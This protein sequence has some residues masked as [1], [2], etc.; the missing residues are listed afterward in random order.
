MSNFKIKQSYIEN[1]VITLDTSEGES[2]WSESRIRSSKL[3]Q[4]DV[5]RLARKIFIKHKFSNILDIGSGPG[6]KIDMFFNDIENV[7][8]IDQPSAKK[9]A[10]KICPHATFHEFNLDGKKN[11]LERKFDLLINADVIEHLHNPDAM[12]E[13]IEG[14]MH[15]KS[16]V[17]ISTPDRDIRRGKFN[18]QSPNPAHVREWNKKELKSYLES[19]GLD[20]IEQINLPISKIN[21]VKHNFAK[22]LGFAFRM[23]EWQGCQMVIAKMKSN[24]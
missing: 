2:Y 15:E 22:L 23:S 3:F 4:Y 8:L 5:Y 16:L 20:V 11:N 13:F 1:P 17:I 14:H 21:S 24:K 6:T 9:I 19:K 12:I 18:N 10:A 7:H